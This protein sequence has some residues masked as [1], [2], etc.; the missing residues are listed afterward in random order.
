MKTIFSIL[1]AAG[2]LLTTAAVASTGSRPV[3]LGRAYV[4]SV[5]AAVSHPASAP[6][7]WIVAGARDPEGNG[8]VTVA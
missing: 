5:T 8:N 2:Q 1:I 4:Q 3:E 7:R 6:T